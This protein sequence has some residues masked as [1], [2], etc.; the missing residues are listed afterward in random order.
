VVAVSVY[1]VRF[2]ISHSPGSFRRVVVVVLACVLVPFSALAA[3][4]PGFQLQGDVLAFSPVGSIDGTDLGDRFGSGAGFS[5]TGSV[6]LTRRIVVAARVAHFRSRR[7]D[8]AQFADG[9]GVGITPQPQPSG[10]YDVR[11]TLIGTPVHGLLQW[12]QP[13]GSGVVL[14]GEAGAGITTFIERDRVSSGGVAR[15]TISG[16]QQNFSATGGVGLGVAL[17]PRF[18]LAGH[19]NL[20]QVLTDS[21][22]IWSEGD[23][24]KFVTATLGVRY[25]RF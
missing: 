21:G 23:N 3:T 18:E 7:N 25:P 2:M 10:P 24:P 13:L 5:I 17:G 12:R 8:T 1:G 20:I 22:D 19:V 6:G 16:Y 15:F 11:R 14:M 9:G 4:P